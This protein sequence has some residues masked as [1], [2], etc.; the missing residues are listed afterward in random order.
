MYVLA[1]VIVADAQADEVRAASRELLLG[2]QRRL[3]WRDESGR[4]RGQI[5]AAVG[6]MGGAGVVVIASGMGHRQQERA[7]RKCM[8]RLLAELVRRDVAR[9]VFE[10]RREKL[11]ARDRAMVGALRRHALPT[12]M[13]VNWERLE[14]EPLL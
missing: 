11:D 14:R 3:H 9:V 13:G 6:D 8:E 5:A 2:R 10:R 4:R 12:A 1:A 7:R